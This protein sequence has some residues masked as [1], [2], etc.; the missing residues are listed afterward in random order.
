MNRALRRLLSGIKIYIRI[1]WLFEKAKPIRFVANWSP[2]QAELDLGRWLV[3]KQVKVLCLTGGPCSGKTTAKDYLQKKLAKE[4][5]TAIFVPEVATLLIKAGLNPRVLGQK[6][7][8]DF[9]ELILKTQMSFEDEIFRS[10]AAIKGGDK[11]VMICDRGCMDGLAY[12]TGKDFDALLRKN[13]LDKVVIR[14]GRYDAVLHLVTAA[15]GAEKFYNYDNPARSETL[16]EAR[17]VD[18]KTQTAWLGHPHLRIIDN[19]TLFDQKLERLWNEIKKVLGIPK[20][21]ETERKF[22]VKNPLS[23]NKIPV[24]FQVIDIKQE[25][26]YK[27]GGVRARIRKRGQKNWGEI[28]YETKKLPTPSALSSVELERRISLAGYREKQKEA[29]PNFD[30]IKKKRA[31]FLWKN[32]YFELDIFEEPKRLRGL[33]LLEIELIK[34]KD[35]VFIPE[36]L[37]ETTDV[38][39]NPKYK[40]KN[41]ARQPT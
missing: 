33:T 41:M 23:F 8:R 15:E 13:R 34:E 1:V 28:Y 12:M 14:D 37:G 2:D 35:R 32:Q 36:W 39:K 4:G 25:Y 3:K 9:Q 29:D 10:A 5:W 7:F 17:I 31:Y 6:G 38:S 16:K 40:N 30:I 22:S 26:L 18:R 20:P 19:S 24:A 21:I 27:K 11:V